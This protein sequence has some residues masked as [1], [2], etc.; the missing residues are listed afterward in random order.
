MQN[1]LEM[2]RDETFLNN[3]ITMDK[4]TIP[5]LTPESRRQSQQW[6]KR[7]QPGP[8]KA[9]LQESREKRMLYAFFDNRGMIYR[10]LAEKGAKINAEYVIDI[11]KRFLHILIR[12]RPEL[13]AGEWHLHWDNAPVH[14]TKSVKDF[15]T[16]RGV[17]MIPHPPTALTWPL[18]TSGC[19]GS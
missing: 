2:A 8:A 17:R 14:S 6:L 9:K 19:F 12:K 15:L 3:I 10:H 18:R 11:L 4:T 1:F 5:Q 7:G 16:K 13:A